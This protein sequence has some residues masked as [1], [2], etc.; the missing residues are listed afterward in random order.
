MK[1]K[2]KVSRGNRSH[3]CKWIVFIP[4]TTVPDV[5]IAEFWNY[6]DARSFCAFKN[7]Q[8]GIEPL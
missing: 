5:V 3:Q 8:Q 7:N 2:Y 4:R 1:V 6:N